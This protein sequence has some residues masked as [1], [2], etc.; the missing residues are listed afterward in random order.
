MHILES[1]SKTGIPYL[2]LVVAF[3]I[4]VYCLNTYLDIRQLR[5]SFCNIVSFRMLLSLA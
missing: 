1:Y 4:G 5:V 3:S 2:E